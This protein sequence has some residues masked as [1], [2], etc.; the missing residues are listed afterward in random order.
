MAVK[1]FAGF[2]YFYLRVG[3][4]YNNSNFWMNLHSLK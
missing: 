4:A 3:A 2:S 1:R